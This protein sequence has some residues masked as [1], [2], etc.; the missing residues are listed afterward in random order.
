M[1]DEETAGEAANTD[2]AALRAETDRLLT[3]LV[4]R[5]VEGHGVDVETALTATMAQ[6]AG[7][8]AQRRGNLRRYE[9][10]KA[11]GKTEFGRRALKK[12]RRK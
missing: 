6:C 4:K 1:A 9:L 10:Q 8:L 11:L 12:L 5:L 3:A 2:R 7:Q